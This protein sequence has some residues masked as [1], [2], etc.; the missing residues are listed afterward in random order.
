LLLMMLSF[1]TS[2]SSSAFAPAI[3][4]LPLPARRLLRLLLSLSLPLSFFKFGPL[5]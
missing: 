1:T 4:L 2:L 3:R 5:L